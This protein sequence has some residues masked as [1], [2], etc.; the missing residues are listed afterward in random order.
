M[1]ALT[2]VIIIVGAI[3]VILFVAY[4]NKSSNV[5]STGSTSNKQQ[6]QTSTAAN[7]NSNQSAGGTVVALLELSG[8]GVTDVDIPIA[9]SLQYLYNL[10]GFPITIVDT[11]SD[12][13]NLVNLI[14]QWYDKG[15]RV[16]IG[17]SDS[18][19][20]AIVLPW[21]LAHQDTIGIS[22]T[23]TA[24][25]LAVNK[26]VIRLTPSDVFSA[27][28]MSEF[29]NNGKYDNVLFITDANTIAA[30]DLYTSML[31]L[32]NSNINTTQVLVHDLS[33]DETSREATTTALQNIPP[34]TIV[35]PLTLN[36][37]DAYLDL[38]VNALPPN[39]IPDQ[40]DTVDLYPTFTPQEAVALDGKYYYLTL[41]NIQ[42]LA[43]REL[44]QILGE[45]FS[46]NAFDAYNIA[47]IAAA[48]PD[49]SKIY[50]IVDH[51]LGHAGVL[52]LN[53][54]SDVKYGDFTIAQWK[55]SRWI[56]YNIAGNNAE[57]GIFIS[58]VTQT[59]NEI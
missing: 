43:N 48:M 1:D 14:Q 47:R 51:L 44:Q 23:S 29:I 28:F 31:P 56:P 59:S 52:E 36:D 11:Q 39:Q 24:S 15:C 16:F 20:L 40:L 37:R 12:E 3:A 19:V 18:S 2:T 50:S 32:L 42:S 45:N 8:N 6:N 13:A 58:R 33:V 30:Q 46:E 35:V 17:F 41:S 54:F 4:F 26:N 25:S 22:L 55:G 9:V 57:F 34:N 10:N 27:Y 5:A 49:K 53:N 21:F 38:L 7:T